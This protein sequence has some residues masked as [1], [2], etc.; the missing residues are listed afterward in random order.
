MNASRLRTGSYFA[1]PEILQ[2][3]MATNAAGSETVPYS[4]ANKKVTL[5]FTFKVWMTWNAASSYQRNFDNFYMAVKRLDSDF[6]AIILTEC[7]LNE[8]T[9][10]E[11]IPGYSVSRTNEQL[12]KNGGIVIYTKS[13]YNITT[14][15]H[16]V[17]DADSILL[18]ID[19]KLA[20][21]GIYRS[22]SYANIDNFTSSLDTALLE[23]KSIPTIILAGDLNIDLCNTTNH[24]H[25]E[26]LCLL[27]SHGLLPAITEP[28]REHTC[29]DHIFIKSHHESIGVIGKCSIT[30]HDMVMASISQKN[31]Y[32]DCTKT[33]WR[34]KTDDDAVAAAIGPQDTGI[35]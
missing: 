13:R 12:N 34:L 29:L 3:N 6:D 23:I 24:R 4:Y 27:A 16:T 33:R 11:P 19:K 15:E 9:I 21:L 25:T 28:T 8:G 26:Y 32:K 14:L 31:N 7:W 20:L 22:P 30:D 17:A 35:A 2:K 10:L 18:T 1:L 5:L